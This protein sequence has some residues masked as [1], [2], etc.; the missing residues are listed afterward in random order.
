MGGWVWVFF[1]SYLFDKLMVGLDQWPLLFLEELPCYGQKSLIT[2][3]THTYIS[4]IVSF[5]SIYHKVSLRIAFLTLLSF[6]LYGR[7]HF[8][9]L[10]KVLMTT[11]TLLSLCIK[12]YNIALYCIVLSG[13]KYNSHTQ[14]RVWV[15]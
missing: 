8:R 6:T 15:C 14:I 3:I 1:P 7:G 9:G 13:K 4:F 10:H 5:H 12:V 11:N 2:L